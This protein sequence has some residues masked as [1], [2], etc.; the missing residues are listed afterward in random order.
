MSERNSRLDPQAAWHGQRIKSL[1]ERRLLTMQDLCD[2]V[3]LITARQVTL[4]RGAVSRW[5]SGQ[6]RVALR[7]RKP[8]ADALGTDHQ[9]LFEDPPEGWVP[10]RTTA[11]A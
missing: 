7:Y 11:V 9:L 4:T 6:R 5:E 10:R 2:E 1:R 8:L 3:E